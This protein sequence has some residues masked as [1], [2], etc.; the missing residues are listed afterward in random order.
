MRIQKF[1][2]SGRLSIVNH[3]A[4]LRGSASNYTVVDDEENGIF[5]IYQC[6]YYTTNEINRNV[7]RTPVSQ[8]VSD[9][10]NDALCRIA[11]NAYR[12]HVAVARFTNIDSF[13]ITLEGSAELG[14]KYK[15][16]MATG[17]GFG[18]SIKIPVKTA[19]GV[20][21][22][23]KEKND[24]IQTKLVTELDKKKMIMAW[25]DGKEIS[26]NSLIPG[27]KIVTSAKFGQDVRDTANQLAK[28]HYNKIF[29][30]KM[31]I[32]YEDF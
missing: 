32:V 28:E 23:A 15:K 20:R 16:V 9:L 18:G 4:V 29:I 2:T 11:T 10:L 8:E 19:E 13:E 21:N 7:D 6:D 17:G 26:L 5:L 12:A 25:S 3:S 22:Q 31:P 24:L 30:G 14:L 27:R 1:F